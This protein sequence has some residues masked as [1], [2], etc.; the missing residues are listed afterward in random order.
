ME[1]NKLLHPETFS[2][3]ELRNILESVSY[4]C[5]QKNRA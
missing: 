2:N 1:N 3:I 5:K 4:L